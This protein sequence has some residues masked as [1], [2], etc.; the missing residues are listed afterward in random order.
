M[1][2]NK[3]IGANAN[4]IKNN[5]EVQFYGEEW[6]SKTCPSKKRERNEEGT[7][8]R[9]TKNDIF[10]KEGIRNERKQHIKK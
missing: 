9:N 2:A 5:I 8:K 3:K 6:S 1:S 7:K 4:I 10:V